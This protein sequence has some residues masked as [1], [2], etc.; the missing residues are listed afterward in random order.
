MILKEQ[1]EVL[2]RD[3]NILKRAVA[4]QHER[5]KELQMKTLEGNQEIQ[6]L[7]QLVGQYQQQIQTLE[8][9]QFNPLILKIKPWNKAV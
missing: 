9:S 4:I 6:H 1:V 5:Q 3:N 2:L 7:K 8:A